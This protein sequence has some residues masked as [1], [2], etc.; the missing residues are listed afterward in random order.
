LLS[1]CRVD[2]RAQDP[3][4]RRPRWVYDPEQDVGPAAARFGLRLTNRCEDMRT[5]RGPLYL[6]EV[7]KLGAAAP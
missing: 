5:R 7:E 2:E 3:A 4:T 6:C 1:T